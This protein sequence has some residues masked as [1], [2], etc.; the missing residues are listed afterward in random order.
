MR[1]GLVLLCM[2]GSLEACTFRLAVDRI[3]Q[4]NKSFEDIHRASNKRVYRG[5]SQGNS[6]YY[7]GAIKDERQEEQYAARR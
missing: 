7:A 1:K 3:P 4:E 2:V 6:H 5:L